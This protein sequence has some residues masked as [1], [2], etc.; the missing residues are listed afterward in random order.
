MGARD[1]SLPDSA[2]A[3]APGS[4]SGRCAPGRTYVVVYDGGCNVCRKLVTTL[5][6]WDRNH[7]LEIIASDAPGLAER[8]PWIPARAYN[9]SIQVVRC[10][11]GLTSQGAAA[12]EVLIDAMPKGRLVSWIFSLPF[13]RPIAENGYRWFAR[14]RY[15]LGCGEHCRLRSP[16][17]E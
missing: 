10:A 17:T 13:A 12:I 8:F 4:V 7:E 2:A 5:E 3:F 14:N 9:E 1:H 11:D 6:R 16:D 15:Y